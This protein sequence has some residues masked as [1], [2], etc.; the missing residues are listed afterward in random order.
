MGQSKRNPI[1]PDTA[2]ETCVGATLEPIAEGLEE[3]Q[4]QDPIPLAASPP[5]AHQP[6]HAAA[7]GNPNP[8]SMGKAAA[9]PEHLFEAADGGPSEELEGS[10]SSE[11]E[12]DLEV[13]IEAEEG[14]ACDAVVEGGQDGGLAKQQVLTKTVNNIDSCEGGQKQ[15]EAQEERMQ[16][17]EE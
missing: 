16:K 14:E 8:S 4:S 3:P 5:Q 13:G 1:A 6:S 11:E 9:V 17:V 2:P 10:E 15:P 12:E 7:G